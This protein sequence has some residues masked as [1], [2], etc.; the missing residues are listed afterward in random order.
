MKVTS[1][2]VDLA[3][4]RLLWG[5][6]ASG[7][8]S[9]LAVCQGY[10]LH[11]PVRE[12]NSAQRVGYIHLFGLAGRLLNGEYNL[13]FVR[14]FFPDRVMQVVTLAHREQGLITAARQPQ[15]N[16]FPARSDKAGSDFHQ[17]QPGLRDAALVR[18]PTAGRGDSLGK[19]YHRY[20][21]AVST[22]TESARKVQS[23][24]AY[25]AVKPGGELPIKLD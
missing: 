18:P 7:Y 17:P 25:M 19:G 22:H 13:P 2:L 4:N 15:R 23:G 11:H 16:P 12:K 14:H 20:T 10:Y 24:A 5:C 6:R 1:G 3:G 8:Q 9:L 21:D